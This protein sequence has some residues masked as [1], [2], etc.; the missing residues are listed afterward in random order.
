M[1]EALAAIGPAP[2]SQLISHLKPRRGN[3]SR[4]FRQLVEGMVRA[5]DLALNRHGVYRLAAEDSVAGKVVRDDRALVLQCDDGERLTVAGGVPVR[6]G[7][8]ATGIVQGREVR[9]ATVVQPASETLVGLLYVRPRAAYVDSL[10]PDLKGR[11]DLVSPTTARTGAVVEV[12]VLAATSSEVQGRVVRVIEAGNE[13]ARAAEALLAAHRIPRE[14]RTDPRRLNVPQAVSQDEVDIRRDLRDL[15]VV[16]IDGADARDFDDAV[17]AEPKPRGGWRLVVA[18]ADVAHYVKARSGLDRDARERGNSVYLPDRVVPMLPEVLSNGI[19]SLVPNEDRLA[20]VCDM[21]VSARGRVSSYAFYD[22]VI[23]SHA[24]LTY[25]TVQGLLDGTSGVPD[26]VAGSVKVLHDVYRALGTQRDERGGLDFDA[27]ETTLRLK[28]GRPVG[29]DPVKRTDA[30]R[31]IEEAMIA[32][33]VAAAR[34]LEAVGRDHPERPLPVYRVHEPPAQEKL[35]ALAMALGIVGEK[36]PQGPVTPRDLAD[37]AQRAR[38]KSRWPAW[39]W[40]ALV[41]RALAQARYEPT[42]LGHFGLALPTYVHFTSPIR[43]YADLLVHRAIKG[44][45]TPPDELHV[46]AGHISM[47][48]RRAEDVERAVDAW[49]KCVLLEDR[50]GETFH[51]IVAGVAP[52]GLFV[53][54]D[55]LYIQGLVHISKLGRDYYDYK[56]ETMSLVAERSGARFTLADSVEVVVEDVSVA[57]G[58]IDLALAGRRAGG[59]RRRRQP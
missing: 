36:L 31:L 45:V 12:E 30:H 41:L 46:A 6:P 13:A 22:A 26:N 14:W 59:R 15:P 23:H 21:R 33:N 37:V 1:R 56:P 17:F 34:H 53:E 40:D 55:G 20:V 43:R 27:H 44:E 2:L 50:I 52:F 29:V 28:D 18:I 48:E 8:R 19:C 4:A 3:E 42:R 9:I 49:L 16:T 51:G 57:N 58:R 7:D 39:V 47:T 25:D 38:A 11:I 24:R 32:A 10:D 5:G 35:D 54:L